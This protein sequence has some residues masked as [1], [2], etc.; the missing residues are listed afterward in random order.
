MTLAR[1]K[2]R[3]EEARVACSS[4]V[5]R[6]GKTIKE[7]ESIEKPHQ[8]Q[9]TTSLSQERQLRESNSKRKAENGQRV[10]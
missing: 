4:V 2:P 9:S 5:Q 6:I 10:R 8:K 7:D 3:P 1:S